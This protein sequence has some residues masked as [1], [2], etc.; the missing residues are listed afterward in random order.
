M[1]ELPEIPFGSS[2]WA[3]LSP[4]EIELRATGFSANAEPILEVGFLRPRGSVMPRIYPAE[5]PEYTPQVPRVLVQ[6]DLL[7]IDSYTRL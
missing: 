2:K 7:L 6:F 3:I 1:G 5:R 4:R